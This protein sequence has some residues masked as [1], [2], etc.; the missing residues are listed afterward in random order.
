MGGK[1][2]FRIE[3]C[4]GSYCWLWRRR[5]PPSAGPSRPWRWRA[6]AT[7]PPSQVLAVA[8][9]K[10]GQMAGKAEFEAARDRLVAIGRVRNRGLPLRPGAG[11]EELCGVVP[12]GGGG[13]GL[14]GAVRGP[15]GSGRGAGRLPEVRATRC[16]R[17]KF[18]PPRRCSSAMR[19]GS[20]S[21][22]EE[23]R[24]GVGQGGGHRARTGSPSSSARRSSLPAVAQVSVH[25]QPGGALD[26]APGRHRRGRHRAALH[27]AALPRAAGHLRAAALR[28]AR[29]H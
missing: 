7:T 26:G 15:G 10:T 8:G 6:T 3:V 11:R 28:S 16:S 5:L 18:P 1:N 22:L 29:A 12:G 14:P 2:V 4:C 23:R 9:L 25:G 17:R 21:S 13:A 19:A 20:R 24:E 27:G